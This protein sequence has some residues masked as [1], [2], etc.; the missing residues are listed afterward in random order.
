VGQEKILLLYFRF[1]VLVV[2]CPKVYS[3]YVNKKKPI[4]SFWSNLALIIA[5]PLPPFSSTFFSQGLSFFTSFDNDEQTCFK[6]PNITILFL[7]NW[8]N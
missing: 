7:P 6:D 5:S 1:Q 4:F 8:T 2:G 3:Y